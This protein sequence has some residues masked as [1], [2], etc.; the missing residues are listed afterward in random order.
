[1]YGEFRYED[2]TVVRPSYLYSRN[3]YTRQI[4][5]EAAPDI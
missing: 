2:K 1:M 5:T 3:S 4:C